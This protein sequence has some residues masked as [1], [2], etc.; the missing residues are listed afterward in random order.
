M[1]EMK[2]T[3]KEVSEM[4]EIIMDGKPVKT[5][6]EKTIL[7]AARSAGIEIPTLCHHPALGPYGSCR[8]CLVELQKGPRKGLVTACTF[9]V[10]EGLE[11]TTTSEKIKTARRFI[12]ELLLARCPESGA[13]QKLA[14]EYG[15]EKPRFSVEK[16]A[17]APGKMENCILCGLCVRVCDDLIQQHVLGFINRGHSR[18][19]AT[20]FDKPSEVCVTCGAC[21]FVCP[22]GAIELDD[23]LNIRKLMPFMNE[24]ELKKCAVCGKPYVPTILFD[25]LKKKLGKQFDTMDYCPSCRRKTSS[26]KTI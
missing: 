25:L 23:V 17:T 20:P 19:V 5:N 2:S 14:A 4:F 10:E 11:V 1:C 6:T 9:P 3:L 12:I 7:Q 13:V 26:S 21:A 22:T 16:P 8:L 24:R 18:R 15:I